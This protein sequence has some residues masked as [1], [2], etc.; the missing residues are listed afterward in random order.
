MGYLVQDETVGLAP[1]WMAFED[2]PGSGFELPDGSQRAEVAG[3]WRGWT[4]DQPP[5]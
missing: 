4:G 5:K 1:H 2:E 3:G